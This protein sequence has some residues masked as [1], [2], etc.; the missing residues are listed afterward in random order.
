LLPYNTSR[1]ND[2][3][4]LIDISEAVMLEYKGLKGASVETI[5]QFWERLKPENN[6]TVAERDLWT[7]KAE[8]LDQVSLQNNVVVF[9]FSIYESRFLFMSDKL[10]VLS[11]LD[12]SHYMA[13]D[14]TYF[15]F[16]RLHPEQSDG[17]MLFTQ[18]GLNF[19][20]NQKL[21]SKSDFITMCFLYRDGNGE[22]VNMLQRTIV[23]EADENNHPILTLN[24]LH[25][26]GHIIKSDTLLLTVS[27]GD[28]VSLYTYN[29]QTKSIDP[30]KIFSQQEKKIIELLASGYDTKAIAQKLFISPH[31]VDNHRRN[32]IKK[33]GCIDTTGVIA[34]AQL[35]N[36]T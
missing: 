10:R 12:A 4:C 23:L 2:C 22:F 29:N 30:P 9:L 27:T 36:L 32:L 18:F 17:V 14:G 3:H 24:F 15:S 11:G 25:Y 8:F 26:V 16:S 6:L 33:T 34:F 35:I 21:H 5:T 19:F 28:E 31:T 7:Q 20:G 13:E 1:W